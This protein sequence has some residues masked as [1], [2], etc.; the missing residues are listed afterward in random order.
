[1]ISNT[2]GSFFVWASFIPLLAT[3]DGFE[4]AVYGVFFYLFGGRPWAYGRPD[5]PVAWVLFFLIHTPAWFM[6]SLLLSIYVRTA[7]T[8]YLLI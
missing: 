1:M 8:N 5:G 3:V 6:I 7:R 2:L 4:P